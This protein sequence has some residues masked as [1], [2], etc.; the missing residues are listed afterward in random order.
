MKTRATPLMVL[1]ALSCSGPPTPPVDKDAGSGAALVDFGD[2]IGEG[3]CRLDQELEPDQCSHMPVFARPEKAS[4]R[5]D[6]YDAALGIDA[7]KCSEC[8][9]DQECMPGEYCVSYSFCQRVPDMLPDVGDTDAG[10]SV[11]RDASAPPDGGAVD[12][13]DAM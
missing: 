6:P 11:D 9:T 4:C 8:H 13:T 2:H 12:P 1:T 5:P 3:D 7:W 10:V